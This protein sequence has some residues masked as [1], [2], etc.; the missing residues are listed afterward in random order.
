MKK[1]R[2]APWSLRIVEKFLFFPK[3]L[4]F[5]PVD[6]DGTPQPFNELNFPKQSEPR[7]TRWF[8]KAR[9]IQWR[10]PGFGWI[11][12]FW[13][14]DGLRPPEHINCRCVIIPTSKLRP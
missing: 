6:I 2:P 3:T 10:I 8:E 1:E 9:I 5:W 11:S 12:Q 4:Q 7:G 13:Y 14:E